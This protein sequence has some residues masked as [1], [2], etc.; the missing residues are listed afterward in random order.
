MRL[1]PEAYPVY[2][3]SWHVRPCR[4]FKARRALYLAQSKRQ[5]EEA[6]VLNI[7]FLRKQFLKMKRQLGWVQ[8]DFELSGEAMEAIDCKPRRSKAGWP[9]VVLEG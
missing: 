5:L 1:E 8:R 7:T 3:S 9:H 4:A 2:P 6:G